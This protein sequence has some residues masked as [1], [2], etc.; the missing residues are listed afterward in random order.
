MKQVKIRMY[1]SN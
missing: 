1:F